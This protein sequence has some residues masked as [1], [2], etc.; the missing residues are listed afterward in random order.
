MW[1]YPSRWQ[2]SPISKRQP[3]QRR[4]P[5]T[6]A[7]RN[8]DKID[9]LMVTLNNCVYLATQLSAFDALCYQTLSTR[10]PCYCHTTF[11]EFTAVCETQ[12]KKTSLPSKRLAFQRTQPLSFHHSFYIKDTLGK[13][14]QLVAFGKYLP[15]GLRERLPWLHL[16]GAC[17][18]NVFMYKY[19]QL[20]DCWTS[21]PRNIW[22]RTVSFRGL[23]VHVPT[24]LQSRDLSDTTPMALTLAGNAP[25][26]F[27]PPVPPNTRIE[28]R[29]Q[30]VQVQLRLP[31]AWNRFF[32]RALEQHSRTHQVD[33]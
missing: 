19:V 25:V 14:Q 28:K 15:A 1:W 20:Q 33:R 7:D 32:R 30:V 6:S 11:G 26:Q 4:S 2:S 31:N 3:V 16:K 27:F 9:I 5:S 22:H 21:A 29:Q 8:S 24:T 17:N 12:L 13:R 18:R 10:H 23:S